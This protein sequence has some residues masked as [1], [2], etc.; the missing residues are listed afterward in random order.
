V[1]AAIALGGAAYAGVVLA[2]KI[3]EAHQ[4]RDLFLSRLRRA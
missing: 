4:V 3:P 1:G 2:L